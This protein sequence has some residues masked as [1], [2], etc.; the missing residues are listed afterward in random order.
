MPNEDFNNNSEE[1][2]DSDGH[3]DEHVNDCMNGYADNDNKRQGNL[4][5]EGAY[6]R[7]W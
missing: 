5:L 6:R 4:M 7:Q 1:G 2:H 3:R